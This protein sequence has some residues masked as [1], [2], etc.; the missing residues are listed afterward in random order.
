MLCWPSGVVVLAAC[1][2]Q[3]ALARAAGFVTA[4]EQNQKDRWTEVHLLDRY[5]ELSFAISQTTFQDPDGLTVQVA[6]DAVRSE[7]A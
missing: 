6:W 2:P 3:T 7:K 1:Q 5:A 4:Q